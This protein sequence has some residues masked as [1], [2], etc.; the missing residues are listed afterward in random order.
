M[1]TKKES[2]KV[3]DNHNLVTYT[4]EQAASFLRSILKMPSLLAPS[5]LWIGEVGIGKTSA[6]ESVVKDMHG[7]DHLIV[8]PITSPSARP[9]RHRH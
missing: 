9:G 7:D 4:V 1:A 2:K 5:Q 3:E 8:P 6:I